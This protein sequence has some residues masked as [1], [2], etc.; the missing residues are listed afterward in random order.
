MPVNFADG[1]S[2]HGAAQL[3]GNGWEWTSTVFAPFPGF[4]PF[5]FY[6]GYSADFFDGKHY[7]MKGGSAAYG[8]LLP[9]SQL[10][11]L[12]S[13]GLS[14]YVCRFP[15]CGGPGTVNEFACDVRSGLGKRQ[16][17]LPSKYLY[18]ELGSALFDAITVLPE[19]GLTR[20]D[21]R[22]LQRHAA[23]IPPEFSIVAELGSGSGRKTR[24]VLEPLEGIGVFSHRRFGA[25][26]RAVQAG[27]CRSRQC[28]PY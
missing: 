1:T 5:P 19:Y 2:R 14:I 12:V 28:D 15:P 16:K 4:E 22:I 24:A 25:G 27:A 3:L 9:S 11:Q 13:C 21:D 10:P 6:P 8:G 23:E 26:A 20:A 7:V 17:E 18:D